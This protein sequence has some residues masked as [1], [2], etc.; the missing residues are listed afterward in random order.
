[1]AGPMVGPLLERLGLDLETFYWTPNGEF[2]DHEPNPLLPE[3]REFIMAE[4]VTPGRR[5]RDRLGRR[6]PTAASSS[7]TPAAS[8]TVTS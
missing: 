5:P 4:V 6:L 7:T 3:N 1:M 8:S 2:P